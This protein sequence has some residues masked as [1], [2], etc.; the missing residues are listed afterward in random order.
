MQYKDAN[1]W[2]GQEKRDVAS[3][4]MHPRE[5]FFERRA[6]L[7]GIG[8]IGIHS[9]GLDRAG[10][11]RFDGQGLNTDTRAIPSC[12]SNISTRNF[13]GGERMGRD[14]QPLREAAHGFAPI[15]SL[16]NSFSC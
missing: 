4:R 14:I 9:A 6:D 3:L 7:G 15:N 11:K 2:I 5:Y 12:R 13:A 1:D 10:R 16:T 8:D